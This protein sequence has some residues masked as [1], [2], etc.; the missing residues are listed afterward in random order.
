MDSAQGKIFV[1]GATGQ[2]GAATVNYLYQNYP[3][4]RIIAAV[5]DVKKAKDKFPNI[6]RNLEIA[7][8]DDNLIGNSTAVND[9]ARSMQGCDAVLV[10]P[11]S[12]GR[13]EIAK[14]YTDAAKMANVKFI[15][16]I[17]VASIGRRDVIL[18]ARQ[19]QEIEH[20]IKVSGIRHSFLR[21]ELFLDNHLVDA[22]CVKKDRAFYYPVNPD[23]RYDPV[24][25]SDVG[26]MA[27]TVMVSSINPN[28]VNNLP[29]GH[30][31][32][33]PITTS[34]TS[35]YS[36]GMQPATTMSSQPISMQRS[37]TMQ[38]SAT[39]V[40]TGPGNLQPGMATSTQGSMGFGMAPTTT[41]GS[42]G[43]GMGATGMGLPPNSTTITQKTVTTTVTSKSYDKPPPMPTTTTT[44]TSGSG[45]MMGGGMDCTSLI[46]YLS[47]PRAISM[48]DIAGVY[49]KVTSSSS[50]FLFFF[51]FMF[52]DP[53]LLC[54]LSLFRSPPLT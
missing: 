28:M 17:S 47:G 25:V 22:P 45:M 2:T 21:C 7:L 1:S 24:A 50:Y 48:T 49:S 13:V 16:L 19:F 51:V 31:T 37:T 20:H 33:P 40:M 39:P 30:A 27:A 3:N 32:L 15:C 5:R 43:M 18:F 46:Y 36:S 29:P 38:T 8:V 14:A 44:T 53:H 52:T 6:L 11:P 35:S 41:S 42:M 34:Q 23:A 12:E 54:L 9:L 26:A 10:V 4:V